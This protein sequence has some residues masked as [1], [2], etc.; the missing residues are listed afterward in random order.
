MERMNLKT[1]Y[2]MGTFVITVPIGWIQWV[3]S[4]LW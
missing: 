4:V 1:L 3:V 2:T